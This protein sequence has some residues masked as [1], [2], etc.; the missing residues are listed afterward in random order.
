MFFASL[1]RH[2][3]WWLSENVHFEWLKINLIG[4]ASCIRIQNWDRRFWK[5]VHLK[6]FACPWNCV[7]LKFSDSILWIETSNE[8]RHQFNKHKN[9]LPRIR[10][11][12]RNKQSVAFYKIS[13]QT[14]KIIEK[15]I[16]WKILIQLFLLKCRVTYRSKLFPSLLI[17]SISELWLFR[18]NN[19]IHTRNCVSVDSIVIKQTKNP[20]FIAEINFISKYFVV[21]FCSLFKDKQFLKI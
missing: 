14:T 8:M 13:W 5:F 20:I 2:S 15:T 7:C 18:S 6:G 1:K 9:Q 19:K 17:E 21:Y 16:I 4:H 3:V 12:Q 11:H 10:P